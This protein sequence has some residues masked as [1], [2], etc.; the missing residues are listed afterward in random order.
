MDA[1]RAARRRMVEFLITSLPFSPVLA[2]A[3][4][5]RP[6]AGNKQQLLNGECLE[7]KPHVIFTVRNEVAER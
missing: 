5:E 3:S 7:Q 4:A 1:K 2:P 6:P